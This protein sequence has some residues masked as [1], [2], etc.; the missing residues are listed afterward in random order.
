MKVIDTKQVKTV[1]LELNKEE[2]DTLTGITHTL[3][4]MLKEEELT[5]SEWMAVEFAYKILSFLK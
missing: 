1:T 4:K 3:G 2:I 5:S